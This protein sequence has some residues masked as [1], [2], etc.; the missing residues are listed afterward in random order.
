MSSKC[1]TIDTV[2]DVKEYSWRWRSALG[3]NNTDKYVVHAYFESRAQFHGYS[4][5]KLTV[6]KSC[7]L[8]CMQQVSYCGHWTIPLQLFCNLCVNFLRLHLQRLRRVHT[9]FYS[10]RFLFQTYNSL[11]QTSTPWKVKSAF[12]K[13]GI[14]GY[15]GLWDIRLL[16]FWGKF[17]LNKSVKVKPTRVWKTNS[18]S[19]RNVQKKK[20]ATF[21]IRW[22]FLM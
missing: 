18:F 8:F 1:L 15:N 19:E 4:P 6:K 3:R 21:S 16:L 11:Y 9:I 17:F 14:F 5:L 20:M 13:T 2:S 10:L 7:L 12:A 22:Y